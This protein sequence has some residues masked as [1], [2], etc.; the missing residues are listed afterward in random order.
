[1]VIRGNRLRASKDGEPLEEV[2]TTHSSILARRIP[3]DR[4]AWWATVHGFAESD[5]TEQLSTHTHTQKEKRA[6]MPNL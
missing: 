3:L 6:K 4:G 2:I 5:T 1:M